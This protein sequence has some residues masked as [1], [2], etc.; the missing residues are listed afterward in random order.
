[1]APTPAG[2]SAAADR[3]A[4]SGPKRPASHGEGP[5]GPTSRPALPRRPRS[6]AAVTGAVL[7]PDHARHVRHRAVTLDGVPHAGDDVVHRIPDVAVPRQRPAVEGRV[8]GLHQTLG[9]GAPRRVGVPVVDRVRVA[10]RLVPDDQPDVVDVHL[11]HRV[12]VPAQDRHRLLDPLPHLSRGRGSAT[13]RGRA[14]RPVTGEHTAFAGVGGVGGGGGVAVGV[15]AGGGV[16]GRVGGGLVAG[17]GFPVEGDAFSGGELLAG[18]VGDGVEGAGLGGVVAVVGAG[19]GG[20]GG[21]YG[22][23]GGGV[24]FVVVVEGAGEQAGEG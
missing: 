18:G 4:A 1:S 11:L 15:V 23:V 21:G 3:L 8:D 16:A 14:A 22:G 9:R 10:A 7:H 6:V 17:G 2:R 19:D 20:G 13:G 5:C 24:V 12:P